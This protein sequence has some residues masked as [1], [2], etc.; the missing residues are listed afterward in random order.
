M[1]QPCGTAWKWL[2]RTSRVWLHLNLT[3]WLESE[4][5]IHKS[6]VIRQS[7][8][9]AWKRVTETH[10]PYVVVSVPLR[11][12]KASD[13][14]TNSD[15]LSCCLKMSNRNIQAMFGYI[16][17]QKRVTE[18]HK[19]GLATTQ[20]VC[21]FPSLAFGL[22]QKLH[23]C[24]ELFTP[25]SLIL[26][27]SD[28]EMRIKYFSCCLRVFIA[29]SKGR[30]CFIIFSSLSKAIMMSFLSTRQIN[31]IILYRD[32]HPYENYVYRVPEDKQEGQWIC[33]WSFV[34]KIEKIS[35][36][37]MSVAI[38]YFLMSILRLVRHCM[39]IWD[40]T[41]GTVKKKIL[42]TRNHVCQKVRLLAP[43]LVSKEY[44]VAI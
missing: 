44:T 13:G 9:T 31:S 6:L 36:H 8:R 38:E 7:Y 12:L 32:V 30:S 33:K 20:V 14:N 15:R 4:W 1:S 11:G 27:K 25:V 41:C 21:V 22:F 39:C 19:L 3:A 10:K 29:C 40:M 28:V 34:G 5:W 43:N 37:P 24:L 18:T 35:L 16:S 2:E 23:L 42:E 17:T 26:N